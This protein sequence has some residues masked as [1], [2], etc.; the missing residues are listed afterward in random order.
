[1]P[2]PDLPPVVLDAT[3]LGGHDS[4][5]NFFDEYL[6][7][8]PDAA[9]ERLEREYQLDEYT[10]V[11]LPGILRAIRI[12]DQA[13]ATAQAALLPDNNSREIAQTVAKFLCNDL[14]ALI[15]DEEER[16]RAYEGAV[17][18]SSNGEYSNITGPQ[19]GEIVVLL[20]NGTISTTMA[21]KLL[22]LLYQE[23]LGQSPSEVAKRHGLQLISDR[24][25]LERLCHETL[26]QNPEQLEQY[27]RGGKHA[28]R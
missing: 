14:F 17:A 11:S 5:S 15:R 24:Q 25:T 22:A 19:L 20:L 4:V 28:Q 13:V 27:R 21:K 3:V 18:D 23:E 26:E 6:P 16:R 9:R 1:M 12:Y 2:E 10:P 8:L 7:D